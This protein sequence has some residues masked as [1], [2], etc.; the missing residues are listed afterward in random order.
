MPTEIT[1]S[2]GMSFGNVNGLTNI[3]VTKKI[4]D[5]VRLDASTLD[6]GDG[7]N[8][9]FVN[10]LPDAGPAAVDGKEQA[11]IISFLSDT[12]PVCGDVAQHDGTDF[13]CV[14]VDIE[15]AVGELVKGSATYKATPTEGQ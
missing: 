2:Q 9:V 5:P 8:R 3:K 15:Y 12:P 6:L 14:N 1:S 7:D 13:A 10:G 4:A 11:V